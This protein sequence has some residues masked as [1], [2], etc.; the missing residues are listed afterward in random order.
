MDKY[1]T[2]LPT[3]SYRGMTVKDISRSARLTPEARKNSSLYYP[4][5][6]EAGFRADNLAEAYFGDAEQ[7][8]LIWLT[9]DIIDPYYN[10]YL[11]EREFE[12]FIITKY[13]SYADAQKQIMYYRNNWSNLDEVISSDYYNNSLSLTLKKYYTPNFGMNNKILNYKRIEEDWVVN[14]NR[15][16]QYDISSEA[17][18]EGE[19]LDIKFSGS[20]V[21]ECTVITSN[22]TSV[23][24]Q[25]V[26]GNSVANSTWTKQLIGETSGIQA[27]TELSTTMSINLS[28]DE[29]AFWTPVTAF[30]VEF[31]H[32]E[33]NKNLYVINSEFA[34]D[35]SEQIRL[36][37]KD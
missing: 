15:I 26:S 32:N 3:I 22:T 19:I 16:I 6:I 30:D 23:L 7:D 14:T 34:I 5:Q 28:D 2:K 29:F 24:V 10:W 12:N 13:G 8:W 25:H 20:I 37:L 9:N 31:E 4:L 1:F 21:G 17:F 27:N 18:T 36:S 11:S 35:L 33:S